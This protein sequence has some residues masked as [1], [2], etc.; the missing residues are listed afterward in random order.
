MTPETDLDDPADEDDNG[1]R[2]SVDGVEVC[3]KEACCID[4]GVN[5]AEEGEE[6]GIEY[7]PAAGI[8]S[9]EVTRLEA[10]AKGKI[11]AKDPSFKT[12]KCA[13]TDD[14]RLS[15]WITYA[16]LQCLA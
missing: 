2:E 7:E 13:G 12:L 9:R 16:I 5:K 10:G 14:V 15:Q 6:S 1:E 3:K 8:V 11:L 4:E